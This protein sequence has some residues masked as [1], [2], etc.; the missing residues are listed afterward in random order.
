MTAISPVRMA[1][2]LSGRGSNARA[3]V[4][5][6]QSGALSSVVPVALLSNKA[7]AVGL[8]FVHELAAGPKTSVN[9]EGEG[10]T[11]TAIVPAIHTAVFPQAEYACGSARDEAMAHWLKE[12][13]VALLVLAGYNRILTP[14]F[15]KAYQ[16]AVLNI[17]PSLLP[18][19]GGP[20]MV[21]LAVHQAVLAD[22]QTQ[23]GCTVHQ[24]TVGVDEGPILGQ[25]TVAVYPDDTPDS[26]AARVLKQEH[27]L[28]WQVI[29]QVGLALQ[30]GASVQSAQPV[31][32]EGCFS[33]AT[34]AS[35][36]SRV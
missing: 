27:Q 29:E 33:D 5:Q 36:S 25:A 20:G 19:Y 31:L 15:F 13:Q 10:F 6:W 28:Y 8:Q 16:G 18:Q 32:L 26:L 30:Q 4:K 21:G 24:V 22:H 9:T 14:S 34:L 11:D 1:I 17:H 23:S 12:H 2:L 3:I 7:D 35:S